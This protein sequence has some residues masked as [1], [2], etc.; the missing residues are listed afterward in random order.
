MS[1]LLRDEGE[2]EFKEKNPIHSENPSFEFYDYIEMLLGE[3]LETFELNI[4]VRSPLNVTSGSLLSPQ[5]SF[6]DFYRNH[7]RLIVENLP[8]RGLLRERRRHRSNRVMPTGRWVN[9]R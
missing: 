2:D 3:Q 6:W 4:Q 9:P 7:S 8:P 5:Y 1:K